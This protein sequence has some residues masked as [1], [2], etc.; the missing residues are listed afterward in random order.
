M[1]VPHKGLVA[2]FNMQKSNDDFPSDVIWSEVDVILRSDLDF[3][4]A[5]VTFSY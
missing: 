3:N 4:N 1:V 2:W 5:L